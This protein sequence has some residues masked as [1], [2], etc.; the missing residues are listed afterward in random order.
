MHGALTRAAEEAAAAPPGGGLQSLVAD[1][2]ATARGDGDGFD[3]DTDMPE[4]SRTGLPMLR[5]EDPELARTSAS[6]ALLGE[7]W[8]WR[9]RPPPSSRRVRTRGG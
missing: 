3:S 9:R 2:R 7:R 4:P 1:A 6:L 5:T 8:R